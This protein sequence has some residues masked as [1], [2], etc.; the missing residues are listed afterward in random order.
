MIRLTITTY[1]DKSLSVMW[2]NPQFIISLR[3]VEAYGCTVVKMADEEVWATERP[4]A[5]NE[6]IKCSKI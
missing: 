2:I 1:G 4:E 3:W 6:L 5:I